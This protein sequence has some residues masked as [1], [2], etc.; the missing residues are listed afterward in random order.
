MQW[1]CHLFCTSIHSIPSPPSTLP[2]KLERGTGQ[3]QREPGS[4]ESDEIAVLRKLGKKM[5]SRG[6]RKGYVELDNEI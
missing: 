6:E 5:E 1:N 2:V 3:D 4:K